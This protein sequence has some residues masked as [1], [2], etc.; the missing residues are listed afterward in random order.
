MYSFEFLSEQEDLETQFLPYVY[1][2]V[3]F[4]QFRLSL[5]IFF[6]YFISPFI[7]NNTSFMIQV[8]QI[9]K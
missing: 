7:S 4:Y 6:I 9:I 5:Y 8:I 1:F 3:L 2:Y